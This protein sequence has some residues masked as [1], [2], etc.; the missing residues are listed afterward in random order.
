MSD[1]LRPHGLQ[2][3]G[4]SIHGIFQARIPEWVAIP[5]SRGS[6]SPGDQTCISCVSCIGRQILYQGDTGEAH[7][8]EP[9]WLNQF[10]I[11]NGDSGPNIEYGRGKYT[12]LNF[13]WKIT[14]FSSRKPSFSHS[15]Q[16]LQKLNEDTR[17]CLILI[18]YSF[19]SIY[20][21]NKHPGKRSKSWQYY[22]IFYFSS[23]QIIPYPCNKY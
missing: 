23:G 6:S 19:Q 7:M 16:V 3:P 10:G 5:S 17:I 8:W 2:P 1:S 20:L 12:F 18:I 15:P 4:S 9:W 11:H 14:I 21:I 13:L 22:E